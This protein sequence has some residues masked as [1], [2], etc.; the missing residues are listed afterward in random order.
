MGSFNKTA[1]DK[2]YNDGHY[3]RINF[4]IPKELAEEIRAHAKSRGEA[5]NAFIRRAVLAQMKLD[6]EAK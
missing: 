2:A 5:T 1:Y 6:S 4:A 3:A